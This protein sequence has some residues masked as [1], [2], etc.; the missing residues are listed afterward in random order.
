MLQMNVI[1]LIVL[2][3]FGVFVSGFFRVSRRVAMLGNRAAAATS[4]ATSLDRLTPA[5]AAP[6]DALRDCAVRLETLARVEALQT[7]PF[8][9]IDELRDLLP[10]HRD[11]ANGTKELVRWRERLARHIGALHARQD[12]ERRR[13]INPV[14]LFV[15][16]VKLVFSAPVRIAGVAGWLD[17]VQV[18][19]IEQSRLFHA[20]AVAGSIIGL[21]ASAWSIVDQWLAYFA[22]INNLLRQ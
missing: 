3:L 11:G 12:A 9:G 17:R 6:A 19:G 21:L 8:D 20:M 7:D 1:V 18:E 10:R 14:G 13:L 4:L 22:Q 16:G 2:L 5:S 15:E